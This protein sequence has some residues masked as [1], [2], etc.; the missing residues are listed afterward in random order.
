MEAATGFE[1]VHTLA[2]SRSYV[3]AAGPQTVRGRKGPRYFGLNT[4]T[5]PA[6]SS[7]AYRF[8]VFV[9]AW[10]MQAP[11]GSEILRAAE[12]EVRLKLNP[13]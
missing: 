11:A 13:P 7:F 9:S 1:L 8:V 10:P 2:N 6:V 4:S 5:R 3:S 12:V